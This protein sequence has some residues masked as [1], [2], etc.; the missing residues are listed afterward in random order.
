MVTVGL[1]IRVRLSPCSH[2]NSHIRAG[3]ILRLS[4]CSHGKS[5]I[6]TGVMVGGIT[7]LGRANGLL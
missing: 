4:P 7:V 3:A 6:R 2:S 1:R 5:H